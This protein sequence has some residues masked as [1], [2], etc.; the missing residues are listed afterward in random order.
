MWSEATQTQNE[1][2]G[3][4]QLVPAVQLLPAPQDVPTLPS[5]WAGFGEEEEA[6]SISHTVC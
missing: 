1:A 6:V 4:T 2:V 3:L 5:V